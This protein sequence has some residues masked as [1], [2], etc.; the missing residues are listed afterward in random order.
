MTGKLLRCAVAWTQMTVGASYSIFQWT[1][2]ELPHLKSR[3]LTSMRSFMAEINASLELDTPG[4]P[5][6]QRQRDTYIMDHIIESNK[7]I[8]AHIR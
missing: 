2:E 3:W 4:A 8:A 7:F 6:T 5:P 1:F